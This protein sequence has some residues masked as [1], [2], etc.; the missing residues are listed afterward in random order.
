MDKR[1]GNEM[2]GLCRGG[3]S[4]QQQHQATR[5]TWTDGRGLGESDRGK[6]SMEASLL[7]ALFLS[8]VAQD[9][10]D[11]EEEEGSRGKRG[12]ERARRAGDTL[13]R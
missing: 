13:R 2:S 12:P 4:Q 7:H 1:C 5:W 11:R 8:G 9:G 3:R 6:V 10:R